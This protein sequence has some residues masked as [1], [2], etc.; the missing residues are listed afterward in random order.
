MNPVAKSSGKMKK[1]NNANAP[2]T[3][4]TL[5]TL[6]ISEGADEK[7]KLDFMLKVATKS[8]LIEFKLD[9]TTTYNYVNS[10]DS[11]G[12]SVVQDENGF[13]L[14]Y[15]TPKYA[16]RH[17]YSDYSSCPFE[18]VRQVSPEC[19]IIRAMNY[20][21]DPYW[22]PEMVPG[23]FGAHCVNNHEQRYLYQSNPNAREIRIRKHKDGRWYDKD[24]ENYSLSENPYAFYDYNF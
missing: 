5:P 17:G 8:K 1:T 22:K 3:V 14:V 9:N 15:Q 23:D 19:L 12:Y 16:N 24:K 7:Q 4:L 11:I 10:K 20:T 2:R 21:P 6:D 13:N 18:V